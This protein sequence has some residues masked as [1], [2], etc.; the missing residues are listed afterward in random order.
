MEQWLD[1]TRVSWLDGLPQ[2]RP[3]GHRRL[4]II[5]VSEEATIRQ[6]FEWYER[7]QSCQYLPLEASTTM[8]AKPELNCV[9][10]EKVW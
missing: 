10:A 1:Y 5:G 6:P 4:D 9:A 3:P 8:Q 7:T 2:S